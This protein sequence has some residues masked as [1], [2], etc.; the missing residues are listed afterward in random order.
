MTNTETITFAD[1]VIEGVLLDLLDE[2]VTASPHIS[3]H[4]GLSA[5]EEGYKTELVLAE[6]AET[7]LPGFDMKYEKQPVGP[8]GAMRG[9]LL[10]GPYAKSHVSKKGSHYAI[11]PMNPDDGP[12]GFH[13]PSEI[14]PDLFISANMLAEKSGEAVAMQFLLGAGANPQQVYAWQTSRNQGAR[15]TGNGGHVVFRTVSEDSPS[16]SWWYPPR[17]VSIGVDAGKALADIDKFWGG[18]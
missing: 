13:K 8:N 18:G 14:D 7:I 16:A 3:H 10:T 2:M 1:A 17:R 4:T 6:S 12:K 5:F 11:I 9:G 15:E